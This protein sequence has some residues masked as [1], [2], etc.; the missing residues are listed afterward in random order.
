MIKQK[1]LFYKDHFFMLFGFVESTVRTTVTDQTKW[2]YIQPNH[3]NF[4]FFQIHLV[5]I[6]NSSF[7]KKLQ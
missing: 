2:Q 1:G 3:C 4:I 7:I 5:R 6:P